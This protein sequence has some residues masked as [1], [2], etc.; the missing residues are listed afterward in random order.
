MPP[1][2][3]TEGLM[4]FADVTASTLASN[5][6]IRANIGDANRGSGIDSNVPFWGT[7]GFLSRPA[8]ADS[9]GA[10]QFLF[11]AD[12]NQRFAIGSRDRRRLSG[13]PRLDPGDR[14]IYAANGMYVHLDAS[15]DRFV[16]AT[17]GGSTM[18]FS[19]DGFVVD[20][21]GGAEMS[22]TNTAYEVEIPTA[23]LPSSIL[24]NAAG[25]VVTAKNLSQQIN[26]DAGSWVTLGLNGGTL[27]PTIPNVDSVNV[28][29]G[30][31]LTIAST[32]VF[33]ASV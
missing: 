17:A 18:R 14:L 24:L 5:G 3:F 1:N 2:R 9:N 16:F 4:E 30:A 10:A 13:L 7:D 6:E 12:G 23:P 28:G 11:F 19:D 26:L 31:G 15:E 33:A 22:F 8:D 29:P 25:L 21:V 20:L 32:K 27:R